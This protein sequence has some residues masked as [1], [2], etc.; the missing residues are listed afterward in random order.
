MRAGHWLT[1]IQLAIGDCK[2]GCGQAWLSRCAAGCPKY[3][4][5]GLAWVWLGA[6]R[7]LDLACT[8]VQWSA[9]EAMQKHGQQQMESP[10][11]VETLLQPLSK[12]I[13]DLL[14]ASFGITKSAKLV[15]LDVG[16][17]LDEVTRQRPAGEGPWLATAMLQVAEQLSQ[18]ARRQRYADMGRKDQAGEAKAQL[19]AATSAA[20]A[21]G[22]GGGRGR[23]PPW[24]PP[25][26][27][28]AQRP[29][30]WAAESSWGGPRGGGG[31]GKTCPTWDGQHCAFEQ[32]YNRPCRD[33][34]FHRQGVNTAEAAVVSR[35]TDNAARR[36]SGRPAGPPAESVAGS[37]RQ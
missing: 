6:C 3:W 29:P 11:A 5:S 30:P 36:A 18:P 25:P 34:A 31:G 28:S 20:T 33:A 14:A 13:S 8:Q 9:V 22:G 1:S 24:A 4:R 19:A 26:T 37:R 12:P 32:L 16:G 15:Q 7:A 21:A 23:G 2:S 27:Q 35:M 10:W 17:V